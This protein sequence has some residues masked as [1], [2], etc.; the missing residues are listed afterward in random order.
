MKKDKYDPKSAHV[1]I[2]YD[3]ERHVFANPDNVTFH[4]GESSFK[5]RN[6]VNDFMLGVEFQGN[7]SKKSLTEDQIKSFIEY[8]EPIIRK[9]KINVNNIITHEMVAPKRKKDI[10]QDQYNR[11]MQMIN[12]YYK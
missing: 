10:T 4:A 1:L 3:G 7:T 11:V 2:G 6:D 5:G 9:N 8:S 12:E